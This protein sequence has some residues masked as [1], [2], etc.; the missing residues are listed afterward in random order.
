MFSPDLVF[1]NH[2]AFGA[3]PRAVIEVANQERLRMAANPCRYLEPIA[4]RVNAATDR[5]AAFVGAQPRGF[6]LVENATAGV[7]TVLASLG[8]GPQDVVLTTSY[9]YGA[10]RNTLRHQAAKCGVTVVEA[11]LPFPLAGPEAVLQAFER[12]W[13]PDLSLVVID[14]IASVPATLMPIRRMLERCRLAGVP[15]LV[16]GA[17]APG[18]VPLNLREL[19]ADYYVGNAHKWLYAPKG[20]AFLAVRSDRLEGIHPLVI[21]H[22]YGAG[23]REEFGWV[24]TRDPTGWLALPAALD[25]FEALVPDEA[26]A[27]CTGLREEAADLLC[28]AWAQ[29]RPVPC[30]MLAQMAT[31]PLPCEV[32]ATDAAARAFQAQL[33]ERHHIEVPVFAFQGR[34]YIRISVNVYNA[35]S[36]YERLA[37]AIGPKGIA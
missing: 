24:G 30:S 25:F 34:C 1:L 4:P 35:L 10:V 12:A 6:V 26:H 20:T 13:R 32:T 9:V 7:A 36:D 21:S 16:D 31:L 14:H 17:H 5:L 11:H 2:G 22:G 27:Y 8:L 23:L 28:N 19:G 37:A 15:V 18:Q 3:T 33:F 29:T